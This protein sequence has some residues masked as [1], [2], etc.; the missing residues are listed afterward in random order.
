MWKHTIGNFA[1][2]RNQILVS[3]IILPRN[4]PSIIPGFQSPI[5][6]KALVKAVPSVRLGSQ[7]SKKE[8]PPPPPYSSSILSS[9][10]RVL[11]FSTLSASIYSGFRL[12]FRYL[13]RSR[14]SDCIRK[15][16]PRVT[17]KE[18]QTRGYVIPSL[19]MDQSRSSRKIF[20]L[21]I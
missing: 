20:H 1:R 21:R 12:V 17:G 5:T 14:R 3:I 4:L 6:V 13:A 15:G 10:F 8:N 2:Y 11:Q 9:T 16:W 7:F 19:K 18:N